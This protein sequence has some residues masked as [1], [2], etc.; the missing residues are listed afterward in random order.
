MNPVY[1]VANDLSHIAVPLF[2]SSQ[3]FFLYHKQVIVKDTIHLCCQSLANAAWLIFL[4]KDHSKRATVE[5]PQK[6]GHSR[7]ATVEGPQKKDPSRR[8]TVEGPQKKGHRKRACTR[9]S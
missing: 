5:G 4:K 6:K 3:R 7:R 9:A 8:A 1:T 2:R